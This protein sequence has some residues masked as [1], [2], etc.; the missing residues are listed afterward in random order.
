[1]HPEGGW[2]RETWRSGTR[3]AGPRGERAALTIIDFLLPAGGFSAFH[4]VSADEIWTH[5]AGDPLE[6]HTIGPD[7][8]H[9]VTRIGP[10]PSTGERPYAVVPADVWQAAHALGERFA[11]CACTVAP[12]FEL[13][14]MDLGDRTEL[15]LRFPQHAEI[16]E[17]FTR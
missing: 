13:A 2:Y 12:G 8:S 11:L 3:V 7:G 6:L 5:Q 10:D 4:R 9:A 14:D 16:I 15:S 17:A 1:M